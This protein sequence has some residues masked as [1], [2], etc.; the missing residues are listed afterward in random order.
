ML[1]SFTKEKRKEKIYGVG[2]TLTM[3][4]RSNL[5]GMEVGEGKE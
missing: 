5:H 4:Y 1:K 3:L 2:E